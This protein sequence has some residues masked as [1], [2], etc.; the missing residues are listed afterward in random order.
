M[1][2]Y[3]VTFEDMWVD[4]LKAESSEHIQAVERFYKSSPRTFP[5]IIQILDDAVSSLRPSASSKLVWTKT[6]ALLGNSSPR[7][8]R[9]VEYVWDKVV[10]AVG[11]DKE[12]LIAMGSLLRWRISLR[13][14][15]WLVFRQESDNVNKDTGKRI[16]ISNYWIDSNYVYKGPA[17]KR[18]KAEMKAPATYADFSSLAKKFGGA[19]V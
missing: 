2:L 15:I 5:K 14:E 13:P 4:P 19:R 16:R 7:P 10:G 9:D 8:H 3:D 1:P 6:G 12:C 18:S 11:D 17:P